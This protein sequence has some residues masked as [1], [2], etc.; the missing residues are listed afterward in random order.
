VL[1]S[2]VQTGHES[3]FIRFRNITNMNLDEVGYHVS[4]AAWTW[5]GK[6]RGGHHESAHLA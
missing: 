2:Y 5:R 1:N 3:E 4:Q 6:N